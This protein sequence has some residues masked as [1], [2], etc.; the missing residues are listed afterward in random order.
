MPP[1]PDGTAEGFSFSEPEPAPDPDHIGWWKDD[2]TVIAKDPSFCLGLK[3][4]LR[5][6]SGGPRGQ[7][8]MWARGAGTGFARP[9]WNTETNESCGSLL[10]S[11][12]ANEANGVLRLARHVPAACDPHQRPAPLCG[13]LKPQISETA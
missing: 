9:H 1:A 4:S 8:P 10:A 7:A 2:Q 5:P 13:R 6:G 3:R 12:R 11:G